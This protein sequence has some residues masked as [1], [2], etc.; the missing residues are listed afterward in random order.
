M[1]YGVRTVN[2]N[3]AEETIT[4]P[5]V[6]HTVDPTF[7]K[8]KFLRR[9]NREYKAYVAERTVLFRDVAT[10]VHTG[11]N[12]KRRGDLS[13]ERAVAYLRGYDNATLKVLHDSYNRETGPEELMELLSDIGSCM[14]EDKQPLI[15]NLA[16]YQHHF[17]GIHPHMAEAMLDEMRLN[18]HPLFAY[19]DLSEME[20][21]EREQF[22]VAL[23]FFRKAHDQMVS[24]KIKDLTETAWV[25]RTN[26][27]QALKAIPPITQ[28]VVE[29]LME[30]V[31]QED[32][33]AYVSNRNLSVIDP[34]AV[35]TYLGSMAPVRNGVL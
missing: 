28:D 26:R 27:K 10:L 6:A 2:R 23:A 24:Q 29:L 31:K 14:F 8:S 19:S 7:G 9:F 22:E 33:L 32:L 30:Q 25:F 3:G 34:D 20:G 12:R 4:I 21:N 18:A 17:R 16:A 1:Q 15:R 13:F 5:V 11:A 35:R